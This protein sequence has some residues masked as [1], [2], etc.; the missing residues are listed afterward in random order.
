MLPLVEGH[1]RLGH[2]LGSRPE[3]LGV[4]SLVLCLAQVLVR[5]ALERLQQPHEV[6]VDLGRQE[7]QPEG[8]LDLVRVR[9]RVGV[10]ARA[11]ARARA[12]ITTGARV[13]ARARVRRRA[14]HRR[15]TR[16]GR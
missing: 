4:V 5:R 1:L 7:L 14:L 15:R 3:E 6:R 8:E 11:R 10:R 9:I 13:R 2:E 12:R 16:S